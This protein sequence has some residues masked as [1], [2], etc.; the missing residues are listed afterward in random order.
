M[1]CRISEPV[2]ISR[3]HKR[4]SEFSREPHILSQWVKSENDQEFTTTKRNIPVTIFNKSQAMNAIYKWDI[5]ELRCCIHPGTLLII[6]QLYIMHFMKQILCNAFKIFL[7][8]KQ[9]WLYLICRT[10]LEDIYMGTTMSLQIVLNT[11]QNP[12]VNQATQ[13]D[14]YQIF[15]PKK[16]PGSKF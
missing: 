5:N 8:G 6:V 16:I 13:K 4:K 2:I 7:A 10:T 11:P 1:P 12:Y 3:K 14:P 9:V 15:L